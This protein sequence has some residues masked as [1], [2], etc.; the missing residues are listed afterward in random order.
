MLPTRHAV[1]LDILFY[2]GT[3]EWISLRGGCG[4][5]LIIGRRICLFPVITVYRDMV[6]H[7]YLL[8]LA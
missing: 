5:R 3:Q 2:D 7:E 1:T 8:V 6:H 4:V